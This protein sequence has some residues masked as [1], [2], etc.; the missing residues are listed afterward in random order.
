MKEVNDLG[1]NE[2]EQRDVDSICQ[3]HD[4]WAARQERGGKVLEMEGRASWV[5]VACAKALWWLMMPVQ[6]STYAVGF[7]AG[8]ALSCLLTG[9]KNGRGEDDDG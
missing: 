6:F 3:Q 7:V 4:D 5:E 9:F 2:A 8:Y 1:N